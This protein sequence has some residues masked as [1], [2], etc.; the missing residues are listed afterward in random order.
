[1]DY[2]NGKIYKILN[3]MN[4]EVY[5]GSTTQSLSKRMAKHRSMLGSK[6]K[7]NYNIYRQMRE[8]GKEHF[9]IELIEEYPCDNVEQLR[10]R[11]G[12]FIRE[13][14]TLNTRIEGRTKKEYTADTKNT[15]REY[16]MKRREEKR[17]EIKEQK[18]Q[19]Y[20]K[21]KERINEQSRI[22]YA[23]KK[24]QALQNES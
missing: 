9:Y 3:D 5:V 12:A 19:H 6:N 7:I 2:K 11:E 13:L 18:K 16:D 1:M 22:K 21:N 14:G 8:L 4:D 24:Q 17:E 15:K 23:L 20:E 10:A